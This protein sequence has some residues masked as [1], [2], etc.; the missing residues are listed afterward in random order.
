MDRKA[1]LILLLLFSPTEGRADC[2]EFLKKI[3]DWLRPSQRS[4][5][6]AEIRM[7]HARTLGFQYQLSGMPYLQ[8]ASL[9][10]VYLYFESLPDALKAELKVLPLEE[11]ESSAVGFASNFRELIRIH[12]GAIE[13]AGGLEGFFEKYSNDFQKIDSGTRVVLEKKVRMRVLRSK[14]DFVSK[15]TRAPLPID[16]ESLVIG[17]RRYPVLE[18][19]S[20]K[21]V[22]RVKASEIHHPY[23]NPV[24]VERIAKMAEAGVRPPKQFEASV[25]MDGRF[26]AEDGNH[27]LE[28]LG[29][30]EW[31]KVALS[32]PPTTVNF[33]SYFPLIGERIPDAD[34]ILD[35]IQK[36]KSLKELLPESASSRIL[37]W[38]EIDQAFSKIKP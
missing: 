38:E 30:D 8:N 26:Y 29:K 10:E 24:S 32:S 31:V 35:C 27:R 12:R 9:P 33:D 3:G 5:S 36:Q 1:L 28:L 14:I 2:P 19:N 16:G 11:I 21:I 34:R 37:F 23:E 15:S 13:I 20:S 25:G 4:P 22:V 17:S 7:D 6:V 18:S